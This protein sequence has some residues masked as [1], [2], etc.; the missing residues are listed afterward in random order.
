MGGTTASPTFTFTGLDPATLYKYKIRAKCPGLGFSPPTYGSFITAT[1]RQPG[2]QSN[3]MVFPNP[4]SDRWTIRNN[5]AI[6]K[7][8]LMDIMGRL[9]S[10]V[11]II[12][13]EGDWV[14]D[15]S[16]LPA[17]VYTLIL[18]DENGIISTEKV[19]KQ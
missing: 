19:V 12:N 13:D 14:M 6:T 4:V 16:R 11:S 9:V 10:E 15:V 2:P 18:K 8:D 17:G 5:A 7:I 1:L 3:R